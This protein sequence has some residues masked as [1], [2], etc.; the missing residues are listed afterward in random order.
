MRVSLRAIIVI[1]G[2]DGM[3]CLHGHK[4]AFGVFCL[5]LRGQA[6]MYSITFEGHERISEL[7]TCIY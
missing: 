1:T 5:T 7:Q 2:A 6:L 3:Q 4:R